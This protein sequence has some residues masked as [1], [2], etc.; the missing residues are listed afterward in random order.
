M[1]RPVT[2]G[3]KIRYF[4]HDTGASNDTKLRCLCSVFGNDGYATYFRLLERIY[5]DVNA[6]LD[7]SAQ[8]VWG[9]V[10]TDCM[11]SGERLQEIIQAAVSMGLFDPQEWEHRILTSAGIQ[12]RK[13]YISG[14]R[15]DSRERYQRNHPGMFVSL[16]GE[17]VAGET[18]DLGWLKAQ[19]T[20]KEVTA[21]SDALPGV[22]LEVEAI[23]YLEF[24][25]SR[26]L[27][28]SKNGLVNRMKAAV[29]TSTTP[30]VP[31]MAD[32]ETPDWWRLRAQR[33]A[34]RNS[35]Q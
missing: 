8:G 17:E 10:A 3:L 23:G 22:Q 14:R 20:D 25:N 13:E 33:L 24:C 12:R 27:E 15:R 2:P 31:R 5:A 16:G 1:A 11:V 6:A 19:F 28:P 29:R 7:L 34:E 35:G 21:L 18:K 32:N 26:Q 9:V 4:P 30:P